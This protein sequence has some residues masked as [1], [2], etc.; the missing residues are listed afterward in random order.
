MT[1]PGHSAPDF[2][3]TFE[4][5]GLEDDRKK[6][7]QISTMV[8]RSYH[9]LEVPQ[10]R[11]GRA[12]IEPGKNHHKALRHFLSSLTQAG[13]AMQGRLRGLAKKSS[14]PILLSALIYNTP[15]IIVWIWER[16]RGRVQ[17]WELPTWQKPTWD[18]CRTAERQVRDSLSP[19]ISL[20]LSHLYLPDNHRLTS[21]SWTTSARD[22]TINLFIPRNLSND[23]DAISVRRSSSRGRKKKHKQ[24]LITS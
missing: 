7:S 15:T 18:S 6:Q 4:Q 22:V 9:Q 16:A 3:A 17:R 20:F 5:I 21:K 12:R 23:T 2:H 19:Q 11:K 10:Q 14:S 8:S 13:Q 24:R 1:R